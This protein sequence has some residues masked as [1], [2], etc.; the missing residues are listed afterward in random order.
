MQPFLHAAFLICTAL[1]ALSP[2]MLARDRGFALVWLGWIAVWGTL[3]VLTARGIFVFS[4]QVLR[5]AALFGGQVTIGVLLFA[6]VPAVRAAVRRIPLDWLVRWQ[7]AR[8]VGGF[9]L[10]GAAMGEVSVPFALIAGV[11]DISVGVAALLTAR[12][13]RTGHGPRLAVRHTAMGLTDFAIAISTAILTGAN[14][15]GP[16]LLIPLFLVP[17]AVLGHLA[18]LDRVRPWRHDAE[19]R[20]ADAPQ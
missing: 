3:A 16:Y 18:V 17:M 8:V 5:L 19:F 4:P 9:F 12:A 7:M 13:M 10:I 2:L 14:I 1:I 6:M 20:L 15:G 11:G